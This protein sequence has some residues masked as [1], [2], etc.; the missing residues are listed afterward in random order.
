MTATIVPPV[1]SFSAILE[2]V[3]GEPRIFSGEDVKLKCSVPDTR[4]TWSYQWFKGTEQL[5]H[6]GEILQLW[7]A[8]IKQSGK[9]YCQGV[10]DTVVGNIYTRQSL[11]VEISVEGKSLFISIFNN[12]DSHFH[13][14]IFIQNLLTLNV[15]LP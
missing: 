10:R 6:Q 9:Y 11:P 7:K 12:L 4:S 13:F 1:A 2:I 5:S 14:F 15:A 8:H 3:S